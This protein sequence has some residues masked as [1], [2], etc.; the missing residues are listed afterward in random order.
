MTGAPI[1]TIALIILIMFSLFLFL[2]KVNR[3]RSVDNF[4]TSFSSI[5]VRMHNKININS[6]YYQTESISLRTLRTM[7]LRNNSIAKSFIKSVKITAI[8]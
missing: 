8:Y 7:F 5:V 2:G 1:T 6:L 3:V 4:L